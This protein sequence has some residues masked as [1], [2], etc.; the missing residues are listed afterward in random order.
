MS[1][2]S[3]QE[4]LITSQ[5][6]GTQILNNVT[7]ASI[8]PA[9]AKITLPNNWFQVG[10][11]LRVTLAGRLSCVVTTPGTFTLDVRLLAVVAFTSQAIPL[12]IVAKTDLP[13]F[14]QIVLTCRSIGA[15]TSATLMG[16][17]FWMSETYVGSP[18]PATGGA[19]VI[20]IPNTAPAV[21]TGFDST[22]ANTVDIFGKFSVAT[23]TTSCTLHQYIL[24]ALN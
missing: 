24:E 22:A 4:T 16:Q 18:V 15:S 14:A 5:G 20:L 7:A 3:W 23:A 17:G 10:R 2:Q 19:G 11:V 8:I 9:A 6:D 13:W 21:G 1:L 12:N